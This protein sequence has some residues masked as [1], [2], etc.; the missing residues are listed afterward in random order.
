[1]TI[2]LHKLAAISA[3]LF[4]GTA[5]MSSAAGFRVNTSGSIPLGLYRT[6]S[7]QV[8]VGSYVQVCPTNTVIFKE[9]LNR[10]YISPGRCD[11]GYGY[12]FKK[13]LAAK[14]DTVQMTD[15]GML[16]NGRHVPF[17]APLQHDAA[18]RP[19][20]SGRWKKVLSDNEFII[21]TDNNPA[22]FDSRYFGPIP[23][24]N[25]ISVITP[26]LTWREK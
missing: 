26:V 22:S 20:S 18:K 11:G 23:R 24:E 17:S 21:M 10:G 14:T 6:N 7:A 19:L 25:I 5:I 15:S 1:M 12:I 3:M 2:D 16:I 9:A 8:R 13:V 4:L